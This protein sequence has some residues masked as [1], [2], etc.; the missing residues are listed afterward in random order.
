[1]PAALSRLSVILGVANGAC[2][3]GFDRSKAIQGLQENTWRWFDEPDIIGSHIM[4]SHVSDISDRLILVY[5][6]GGTRRGE[7]K[8]AAL[9]LNAPKQLPH[10]WKRLHL[11]KVFSFE[12]I[13]PELFDLLSFVLVISAG[14]NAG[15]R[16][17]APS[18]M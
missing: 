7:H 14:T 4:I 17:S 5:L 18:P 6:V 13:G 11:V 16:R 12:Q 8:L 1:M 9:R 2:L 15:I 3:R 10:L